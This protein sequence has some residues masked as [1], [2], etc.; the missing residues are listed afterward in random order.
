[1]TCS[2]ALGFKIEEPMSFNN[3][4]SL[5]TAFKERNRCDKGDTLQLLRFWGILSRY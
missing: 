4:L 2:Y 5:V 1:M 3:C